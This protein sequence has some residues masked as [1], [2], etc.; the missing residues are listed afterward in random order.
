ML[1]LIVGRGGK[2]R[3]TTETYTP[4]QSAILSTTQRRNYDYMWRPFSADK[5]MRVQ[6]L[7]ALTLAGLP[8]IILSVL[9]IL[10]TQ[11]IADETGE[12]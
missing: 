4:A 9:G 11:P 1:A 6:T 8:I 7:I 10:S 2:S 3:L 5:R 12:N